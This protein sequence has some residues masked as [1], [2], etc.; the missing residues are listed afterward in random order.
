MGR[1]IME[2][3]LHHVFKVWFAGVHRFHGVFWQAR[4][5]VRPFWPV[6]GFGA[7]IWSWKPESTHRRN[8]FLSGKNGQTTAPTCSENINLVSRELI[9]VQ[10]I[11]KGRLLCMGSH[12]FSTTCWLDQSSAARDVIWTASGNSIIIGGTASASATAKPSTMKWF[13]L[14]P[15][16]YYLTATEMENSA[17]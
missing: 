11:L 2:L 7:A 8:V 9:C 16:E 6:V 17:D 5:S 10:V 15:P 13:H 12:L 3:T 1:Y 14:V 4:I